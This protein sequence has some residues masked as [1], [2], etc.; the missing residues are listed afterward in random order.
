MNT[1]SRY[2]RQERR[3]SFPIA[4]LI[5]S[6]ARK[7][8][9]EAEKVKVTVTAMALARAPPSPVPAERDRIEQ[10]TEE[11]I[12]MTGRQGPRR[13]R[14][15]KTEYIQ[16]LEQDNTDLQ[17]SITDLH[18]QIIANQAQKDILRDQLKYF[19][20]CLTQAA[21]LV[22]QQGGDT[23]PDRPVPVLLPK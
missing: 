23:G 10:K 6:V 16:K 11:L 18:Q 8:F 7:L 20:G 2:R 12:L 15:R 13:W 21:P 14:Q 1:F 17:R 4:T 9:Y 19:Q 22:F 5:G 3:N